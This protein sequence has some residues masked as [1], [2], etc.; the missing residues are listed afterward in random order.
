MLRALPGQAGWI[1]HGKIR[2]VASAHMKKALVTLFLL[3]V[4]S[5][6]ISR[7]ETAYTLVAK[8]SESLIKNYDPRV[9]SI[10]TLIPAQPRTSTACGPVGTDS[11]TAFYCPESKMIYV[12]QKTL[13]SVGRTYGSEGVATLVAHE[14]AHARLHAIQGFTRDIVWTSVIDELQAD[15]VAGV[16][17]RE[18]APISLSS[19]MVSKAANF[20]ENMG[21]Y[22]VLERDWH[23]SPQMRRSSFLHGYNTGRLS[24]CVA[25]E[26]SGVKRIL[27]N[28]TEILQKQI[29]NP[30]S[31][32]NKIIRWGADM[33]QK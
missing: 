5:S 2:N 13:D 15:C 1:K 32:L 12:T 17:M 24:A 31:D 19:Q 28:P 16:Y 25:T 7:A 18:A 29:D 20:V 26:E 30:N 9:R 22:L 10:S 11:L 6:A 4:G 21:D 33:L 23:G 3:V 8:A 14:F 27:D